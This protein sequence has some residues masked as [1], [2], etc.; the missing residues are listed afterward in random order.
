MTITESK[1]RFN[2]EGKYYYEKH[3]IFLYREDFEKFTAGL[4]DVLKFIDETSP[5]ISLP[6][7]EKI[8]ESVTENYT[9]VD[10]DDLEEN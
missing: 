8:A 5:E 7:E 10:F 4:T 2:K 9:D 3:K 6:E 1:K